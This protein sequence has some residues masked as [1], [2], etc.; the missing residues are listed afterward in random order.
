M[1][2]RRQAIETATRHAGMMSATGRGNGVGRRTESA[3]RHDGT[4]SELCRQ[5][6]VSSDGGLT[7]RRSQ[8]RSE[9]TPRRCT[10]IRQ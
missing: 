6:P 4:E 2:R 3:L 5:R 9:M 1:N 7:D 10:V 8:G